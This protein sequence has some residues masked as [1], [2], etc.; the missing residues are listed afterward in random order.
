[1]SETKWTPGPWAQSHRY[2]S[3]GMYST[4]VYDAKSETIATLAWHEKRV[5]DSAGR[6]TLLTDRREN[7]QLI[8]AA[9]DLYEVLDAFRMAAAMDGDLN[10]A[11]RVIYN[12]ACDALAKA[13]GEA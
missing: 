2:K 4:E 10:P 8:A 12:A 11:W 6:V 1:V 5:T 9:P 7:A 13:R 3:D